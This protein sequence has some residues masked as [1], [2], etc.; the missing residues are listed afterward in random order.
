M[1][2]INSLDPVS[3]G[4]YHDIGMLWGA[5][6]LSPTGIFADENAFTAEGGAIERH[7]IFMTDGSTQTQLDNVYAYG[8]P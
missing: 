5:R 7:M 3:Q 6:L 1:G 4:T 2:Y 8:L